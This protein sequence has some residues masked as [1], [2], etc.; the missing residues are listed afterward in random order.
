MAIPYPI[1]RDKDEGGAAS[2]PA[3]IEVPAPDTWDLSVLYPDSAAWS[4]A[5]ATLQEEYLQIKAYSGRLGESAATLREVLELEKALDLQIERLGHFASLRSSEDSSD[6]ENLAREGQFENLMTLI[7][8]AA[9]FLSPEIQA[10]DDETFEQYLAEPV[11][12]E[13]VTPLRKLRR[14]KRH[15]LST[16]EERLLALGSSALHGH[17]ETFSQ[18]TNVDMKFG[19]ILDEKGVE[20]TLTQSSYSSFL[21]KRD[22]E[23]RRRAFHQFYAEFSDHQYTLASS[24]A[25]SVKADVFRARARNYP[26][27]RAA[28]LFHDDVPLAVYDN[29]IGSVRANLGPLFRYYG[30]RKKVLQLPEIHQYDTYVPIVSEIETR[31]PFNEAIEK[32]LTAL[33]PLGSEYCQALGAGLRTERWCDRYENKGK[34]SGAFSSSS[35]R[36]PP[37][38]LMNYKADVFSDIY[39]LAHEAGHSMHSWYAQEHAALPDLQ[40]PDLPRGG[41]LHFQRGAAHASP[42]GSE[43][44][45]SR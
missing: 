4:A 26:G 23:L 34:R 29:L 5:F 20:R 6:A 10:I 25:N 38:I 33:K 8:E 35:Y 31:V 43:T 36:N 30:L 3:R 28:A 45:G 22:P 12:A 41:G 32:V 37:F 27:A 44:D 39:T 19:A 21:V 24:L 16:A 40:L 11:L 1:F 14:L 13:W 9:S 7:G 42:A 17:A 2:V 15:T 18:L